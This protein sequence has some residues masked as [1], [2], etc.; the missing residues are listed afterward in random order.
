MSSA[1][2]PPPVAPRAPAETDPGRSS[3]PGTT[4]EKTRRLLALAFG[5]LG[6]VYGDIGTSPLYALRACFNVT[7]G[8]V[9]PTP[10]NV[11]GVL[12]LVF[13]SLVLVISL[14]YLTFIMRADNQG[15]GG[16]LALMALAT[17]RRR[18]PARYR[19][20]LIALGLFGTALL[21]GDGI[22]T[23]AISVLGAVEGLGEATPLLEPFTTHVAVVII[24][25]IF[26]IQRWGTA[27]VAALFSPITLLWFASIAALGVAEILDQ[28]R[29]LASVNPLYA[30]RF[31][32]QNGLEG[33][34]VLAFVFL[35]VT[36][37]EALYADMGHFGRRPIR[38]AWFGLVLPALLLNYFGQGALLISDPQAAANPFYR[39]VPAP[40]LYPMIGLATAAAVVASQALI[41]GAFS[42]T[43]QA[44]QLGYAP[45]M[46]IVHTSGEL[47]GRI[48]VSSVNTA[49]MLACIGVVIGFGSSDN[50]AAAYGI[51]VTGTMFI[52]TL[53][54]HRVARDHLGWSPL[55]AGLVAGSF[56]LFDVAFLGA[57]LV[58]VA[59]GGWFPLVTGVV[60]Y[61][62]MDT[63]KD[64]RTIL[65]RIGRRAS[66]PLDL[67]LE[68]L[69]R[70]PL[71]RA[72]GL[73]VFMNADPEGAPLVLLHHLKHNRILHERVV[74]LSLV[75][76]RVPEV[77]AE[78]R[79]E[80]RERE[81]GFYHVTG[82]YGFMETPN[83]PETLALS[84]PLK[85]VFKPLETTYYLGR[86]TLLTTGK[87]GMAGWRKRLFR[88][89]ARNARPATAYF[90]LP[91]NRVVELGAQV[92]F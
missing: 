68:D 76:E 49:L 44:L 52:T 42:L 51:A 38:L 82:R 22:I 27:R 19:G 72:S 15:E 43:S 78:E 3:P 86:Q 84:E 69:E 74:L 23:P 80:T 46:T 48:Y 39:L 12:S 89:M 31:F 2:A 60:V 32:V 73:G 66:I 55:R 90:G 5:T 71:P 75:T 14:K 57:N 24:V 13:W 11:Y 87:S 83:A 29:V 33:F 91:P 25:G 88:F 56:L 67:L 36:G 77:P 7:T 92:E 47:E 85:E 35:V 17:P 59:H 18:A 70:K 21:Y 41:S 9:P 8:G 40:L 64:G 63:W 61:L 20:L 16:I 34:L 62:L 81:Q 50:L 26:L 53:L 58:K 65:E 4:H 6:V 54:F 30:A 45:R 28:P 10:E 37:G 1:S 79:V